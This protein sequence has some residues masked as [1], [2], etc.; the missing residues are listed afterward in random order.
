MDI[1]VIGGSR[2][3]GLQTVKW[4]LEQGHS[5]TAFARNPA[6]IKFK[7]PKLRL[8]PGNVLDPMA[9]QR[10]LQGHDA[11]ICALGLPTLK[12]IGP[13]VTKR[14]YVLSKGTDNIV[15]AMASNGNKRFICVTAI[16]A[17]DSAKL[18]TPFARL[19]LR[20]GLRWLFKE[21]DEQERLIK[22]SGLDWTIIRP[23]A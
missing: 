13:P 5:V 21:K 3:I 16:G 2:G 19:V 8:K 23:T 10:A 1:L 6:V 9:V 11:V 15:K 20:L 7:H 22:N 12:A 17:G 4:G 14:S 18:C